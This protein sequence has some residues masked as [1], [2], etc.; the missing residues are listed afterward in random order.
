MLAECLACMDVRQMH[1][2]KRDAARRERIAQCDTGVGQAGRIDQDKRD[3]FLHRRL[4]PA[5]EFVFGVALEKLDSVTGGARLPES[6]VLMLS[7]CRVHSVPA[8]AHRAD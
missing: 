1:F 5:D 3:L 2:D 7:K 6:W 8:R 4:H